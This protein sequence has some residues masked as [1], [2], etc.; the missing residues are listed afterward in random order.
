MV[1]TRRIGAILVAGSV[2]LPLAACS[3]TSDGTIVVEK[4]AALSNIRF[5][6]VKPSVPQW[7]RRKQPEPQPVAEPNFPPPPITATA[8]RHRPRPPVVQSNAGKLSCKNVSEGGR[9]RMVCQ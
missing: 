5:P 2:M 6:E 3:R 8:P 7:M 4:P 9:V 1:G